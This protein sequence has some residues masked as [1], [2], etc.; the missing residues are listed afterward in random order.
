MDILN[1]SLL[2]FWSG[3]GLAVPL[4]PMAL[5]LI[6][7]T[8]AKGRKT[9]TFA[10]LAM[11]TVDFTYAWLV[12]AVGSFLMAAITPLVFPL[13]LLGSLILVGLSIRLYV[14]SKRARLESREV[15][16]E[17]STTALATFVTFFG[18]TA[19]NPATA[20]YFFAL[21]PSVSQLSNNAGFTPESLYFA[22]AVFASSFLWQLT[23]VAGSNY[24]A[25]RMTSGVQ[26]NLQAIGACLIAVL[27]VWVLFR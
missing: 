4:G 6:T 2:G 16:E 19:I 18:L 15:R 25:K 26:R 21:T 9:G 23:L 22:F 27:A 7:T 5:L 11:A 1:L 10:A 12:F 24:L 14:G 13:R 8:I 17:S 3:L 20:F